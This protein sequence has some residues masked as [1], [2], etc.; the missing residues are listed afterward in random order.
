MKKDHKL[1][2]EAS[3]LEAMHQ[4]YNKKITKN[5]FSRL[6]D[7]IDALANT[8]KTENDIKL[9]IQVHYF[10]LASLVL[11]QIGLPSLPIIKKY[12]KEFKSI[13]SNTADMIVEKKNN[14]YLAICLENESIFSEGSGYDF[15]TES[16][17][18]FT[19]RYD[20]ISDDLFTEMQKEAITNTYASLLKEKT[21]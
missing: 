16:L 8:D 15:I 9:A 7:I 14:N 20:V 11:S 13:V 1:L 4:N 18:Q 17:Y 12:K 5:D 21:D 19:S 3:I 2:K 10:I 6:W